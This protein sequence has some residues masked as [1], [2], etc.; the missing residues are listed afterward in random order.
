[1]STGFLVFATTLGWY[2]MIFLYLS[3]SGDISKNIIMGCMMAADGNKKC[4][5]AAVINGVITT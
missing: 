2:D 1:M 5:R 4:E 3:H